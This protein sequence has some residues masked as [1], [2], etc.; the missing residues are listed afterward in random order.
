[1]LTSTGIFAIQ[2][3]GQVLVQELK[4]IGM[5]VEEVQLD[6][7]T[8]LSRRLNAESVDKGGWSIIPLWSFGPDLA[9]PLTSQMLTAPCK[10]AGWPGWACSQKLESLVDEWALSEDDKAKR[11]KAEEIQK[12]AISLAATI[13]LGQFYQPVAY[14]KALT[15]FLSAPYPTM[16]NLEKK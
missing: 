6:F 9:N 8:M 13:P 7:N 5:N 3:E 10:V 11:A 16:W 12:E 1:M 2:D 14:R 4:S 15:G